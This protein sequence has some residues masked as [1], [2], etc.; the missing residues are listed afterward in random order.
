MNCPVV[1]PIYSL[2]ISYIRKI[3]LFTPILL[4]HRKKIEEEDMKKKKA[5]KKK[6]SRTDS[7]HDVFLCCE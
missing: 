3:K 1:L 7:E 4:C 6:H 5:K 2:G